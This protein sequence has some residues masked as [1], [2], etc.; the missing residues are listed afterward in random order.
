MTIVISVCPPHSVS[1]CRQTVWTWFK[2]YSTIPCP[3]CVSGCVYIVVLMQVLVHVLVPVLMLVLILLPVIVLK[4]HLRNTPPLPITL[5]PIPISI[6]PTHRIHVPMSVCLLCG[7]V[8]P[9]NRCWIRID[10][11]VTYVFLR[12]V[13][14]R[15][16]VLGWGWGWGRPV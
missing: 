1:C 4:Y 13:L 15:G 9:L 12:R 11:S 16:Q 2:A 3:Y 5:I 14:G 10:W 8:C 7:S 6:L